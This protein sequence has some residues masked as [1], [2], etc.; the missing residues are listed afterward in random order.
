MCLCNLP[1]ECFVQISSGSI[2]SILNSNIAY[3][4]GAAGDHINS[5]CVTGGAGTLY[6][7][8]HSTAN[9]VTSVVA[10]SN[11]YIATYAVTLLQILPHFT[12]GISALQSAVISSNG[13]L[14]LPALAQCSA[15]AMH[16]FSCSAII[17]EDAFLVTLSSMRNLTTTARESVVSTI[18]AD[19]IDLSG[20]HISGIRFSPYSFN[21][22]ASV[23]TMSRN[24][25]VQYTKRF[26]VA[27]KY[28]AHLLG[29]VTQTPLSLESVTR[30]PV[31]FTQSQFRTV[32][33]YN[34]TISNVSASNMV[35]N[36]DRVVI[37]SNSILSKVEGVPVPACF[38]NITEAEFSCKTYK[39]TGLYANNNTYAFVANTSIS[40]S[41]IT[42]AASQVLLCAPMVSVHAG[43][44]ID[45]NFRGCKANKGAGAGGMQ[46][47]LTDPNPY[48]GG[49]GGYGGNGGQ[50][51]NTVNYGLAHFSKYSL[52]SGSGGGCLKCNHTQSAGGG[53]INIVANHTVLQGNLTAVG[54]DAR[55]GA[56]G[57]SGGSIAINSLIMSGRGRITATGGNGG[58]G[59]YPGGGGGGGVVSLFNAIHSY[60]LYTFT[61]F[62]NVE[63][64]AVYPSASPNVYEISIDASCGSKTYG[65]SAAPRNLRSTYATD[66]TPAQPGQP[67]QKFLPVCKAG[68]GNQV[69]GAICETCPIGT[70]SEGLS[71]GPCL[72]CTNAPKH[73]YY[74]E[75]GSTNPDCKYECESSYVTEH[76]YN[77][78]QNFIY[79]VVGVPGFACMCVGVF[80]L[81]MVPL[82]YTRLKRRYG[83]FTYLDKKTQK[84]R[85]VFGFDF[86]NNDDDNFMFESQ[87]NKDRSTIIKMETFTTE[88]PVL[89]ASTDDAGRYS[90]DSTSASTRIRALRNKMFAERRREH[91]MTD[92]DL[93]FHA[94]R[95]NL[96]GSNHPFQSRGIF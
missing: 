4:G 89:K 66:P 41:A 80:L 7:Q 37:P 11:R 30:A 84:R 93:V 70:Y 33:G 23:F 29:D 81:L 44:T 59:L 47:A 43:S 18:S 73:A 71:T 6:V 82:G 17:F 76:C 9:L 42:V 62:V 10:V 38:R 91:R 68:T 40:I 56:G 55:N 46:S 19:L 83:Y 13:S 8:Y 5:T 21:I 88:N 53:L 96:F 94:Y 86:F 65:Y 78:V 75:T 50:G 14:V 49:G 90:T 31:Y 60:Q 27:V 54:S 1:F 12:T 72:A 39:Y 2:K 58:P 79:S 85:D 25:T 48:G 52:S 61:G 15:N 36:G 87:H 95:I 16:T 32:A 3:H 64:G 77:Q 28:N 24:S 69:S 20:S 35:V 74:T 34:V 63:G 67:G 26:D 51:Y 57:G 22:V 92:Q 45:V